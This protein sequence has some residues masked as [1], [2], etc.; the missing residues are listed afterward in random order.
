VQL[1]FTLV[2]AAQGRLE[3]LG[4]ATRAS[5]EV[6][7]SYERQFLAG[8]KQWLDLMNAAREQ[9]QSESQLADALGALQLSGWRLALW[10]SG[11]DGLLANPVGT[12]NMG[13]RK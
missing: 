3:G 13:E 1:D 4:S 10:T 6:L 7:D 9:A 2:Q 5:V 8:R 12:A 11:V